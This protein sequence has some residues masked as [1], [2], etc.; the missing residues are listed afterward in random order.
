M[1][2]LDLRHDGMIW[3]KDLV[4]I[5]T[6]KSK[7]SPREGVEVNL[8]DSFQYKFVLKPSYSIAGCRGLPCL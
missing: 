2:G 7:E 8:G 5:P 3:D 4:S 6:I 1:S